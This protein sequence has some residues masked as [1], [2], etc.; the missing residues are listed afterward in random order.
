M[1]RLGW[2]GVAI[3]LGGLLIRLFVAPSYG[4]MGT[5]GD[6]LEQKQ[7]MHR[8]VTLGIHE[9]YTPNKFNDPALTG[10]DWQGGYFV[11]YPPVIVYLRAASGYL[12]RAIAPD[13][14]DLWDSELNYLEMLETDLDER[15]AR[16]R[17]FTVAAKLPGILADLA[18]ATGLLLFVGRRCGRSVGLWVAAAYSFNPGIIVNSAHW[19]QHDAVWVA[20]LAAGLYLIEEGRTEWGWAAYTLSALSKPQAAPF[21]LLMF[22]LGIRRTAARHIAA[23]VAV[24]L[25]T[26][27]LV[28]LPFLLHGTFLETVRAIV[29]SVLGGEPFVSCNANNFWWLVTG[30]HGYETS[31][32]VSIAGPLTPRLLGLL[33]FLAANAAL[34]WR[35]HHA[36]ASAPLSFL[37]AATLW[38]VF[39]S[40]NTELHENHL[41]G[42]VPLLAFSLPVDRRLWV[43]LGVVSVTLLLNLLLFDSSTL[44]PLARTLGLHSES[45]RA[46]SVAVALA[47]TVCLGGVGWLFWT[48]SRPGAAS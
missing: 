30:G 23:G 40:F 5:E 27:T 45:V 16:S 44:L 47:N 26:A 42:A 48:R 39:F 17:G 41:M 4:Y 19:G 33:I 6:L 37:A 13:R 31:D 46:V 43:P 14:F 38:M 9:V 20:L 7:A 22:F 2:A 34:F 28:F 25:G 35:L 3:L 32:L 21:A 15:L 18:I 29:H 11:N 8:A 12:Y 24:A 36:P 10:G 1:A